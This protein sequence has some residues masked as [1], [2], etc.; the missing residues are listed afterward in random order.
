MPKNDK[1]VSIDEYIER[2]SRNLTAAELR[3]LREFASALREKQSLALKQ[4]R[5]EL[6]EGIDLIIALFSTEDIKTVGDP[7]PRHLAEAGVA[8]RYVLKGVDIIPDSV[9]DLGLADDE[10]IVRR[11]L[12]RNPELNPAN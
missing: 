6:A 12:Q 7:L 8:A 4:K 1:A 10:W 2:Q 9:P 3:G 5:H 11:V